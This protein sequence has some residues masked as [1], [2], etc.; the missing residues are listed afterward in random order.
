MMDTGKHKHGVKFHGTEGR[1]TH[2]RVHA[3]ASDISLRRI[4]MKPIDVAHRS[5]SISLIGGIALK[6][7]RKLHWNPKTEQ[8]VN[9]IEANALLS[10]PMRKPWT[11]H[12]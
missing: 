4:R 7:G 11:L 3:E 10:Y 6:L 5:T 9:D 12:T 2:T 1:W 8:F